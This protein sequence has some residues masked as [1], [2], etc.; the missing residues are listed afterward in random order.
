MN[1]VEFGSLD[2]IKFSPSLSLLLAEHSGVQVSLNYL[3]GDV[4]NANFEPK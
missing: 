1:E 2:S 3:L 4:V